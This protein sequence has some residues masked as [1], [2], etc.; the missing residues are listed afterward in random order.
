MIHL[1]KAKATSSLPMIPRLICIH[2]E[3]HNKRQETIRKVK[4]LSKKLNY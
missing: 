4:K 1:R 3:A 2:Y